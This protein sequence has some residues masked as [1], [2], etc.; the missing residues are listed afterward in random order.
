MDNICKKSTG[1][2]G[3]SSYLS[4]H[5]YELDGFVQHDGVLAHLFVALRRM[6]VADVHHYIIIQK[7]LFFFGQEKIRVE[8]CCLFL[9]RTVDFSITFGTKV[10][11]ASKST[12][13][14]LR[15]R[16]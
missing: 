4:K 1:Q 8:S 12:A 7:N 14:A 5:D 11:R 13:P 15:V 10:A 16:R 3:S 9:L 6:A 2:K